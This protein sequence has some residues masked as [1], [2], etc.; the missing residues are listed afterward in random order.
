MPLCSDL[1]KVMIIGSG[2]IVIGQAAEF[3]YAGTQACR[4]LKS[5][6][7]ELVLVN[8]NPA[9]IMTDSSMADK[10]YVEPLDLEILRRIIKKEKPDGLLSTLGGQSGL[11]LSMQL[12]KE[13]FLEKQ[14]VRL[15]GSKYETINRAE[16]RQLFKDTMEEIG[17]PCTKSGTATDVDTAL[18]LARDIGYPVIIRPAF[19]LG[20]S[21][22]G[23]AGNDEELLHAAKA[24]IEASPIGQI[25]VER[26]VAGWKEIEFEVIRDALGNSITVCSMEN[27]DPVGVHTGDSVVVAPALTLAD[28][29][30][31]MLRS[32]AL[33][34][35]DALGVEGGCNV[36]YALDPHSFDYTV[37]EVNPRVSRSSALASK[38]TGYP[39]AKVA[40][41]IAV[42]FTLGEIKN[43]VTGKTSAFFEPA[44]DYVVVKFPKWPFDKFVYADR[45]L[46]TQMK[47]TGEVM[48][49]A[50]TFEEALM[51]AVRGAEL[52]M[53]TLSLPSQ[54]ELSDADLEKAAARAT[55]TRLFAVYEA[56]RRGWPVERLNE[57]TNIDPWFLRAMKNIC[58]MEKRLSQGFD[59]GLY[60]D[61]KLMSFTDAAIERLSGKK[62]ASPA[63]TVFRM[64]DTCAA[65][66]EAETPYF[67]AAHFGEDEAAPY[68]G[69]RRAGKRRILVLGSGPIRIG[70]G[71]EFDY[72]CVKCVWALQKLGCEVALVNNNPE[73]VSTDFDTADRLY[74][75]PLTPEDVMNVIEE[76]RPD[77]VVAAFG[78]GTAIKLT[79]TLAKHGVPILGTS[80]DSIDVAEDRERFDRILEQNGI[81][82]PAGDTVRTK[83]EAVAAANKLGYPV[84]IRPS[85]VLGGQ[86]MTIAACDGDVL[87]YMEI[88][89]ASGNTDPILID[90][91]LN[92]T[93]VEVDAVCDGKDVLI[94]GVMAHVERAGVHSGDSI[95]QYPARGLSGEVMEKIIGHTRS[96]AV[97]LGTK[98]LINIQYVV[99]DNELYVIEANPRASRTVPYI[100]KITGVPVIDLAVRAML[101]EKLENM[102]YGTGLYRDAAVY[103]AKVPVFSFRKL[104]GADSL[105]GPEMKSTGEVLGVA[106][107]PQEALV[108]GL[109]AAGYDMKREG[110][111]LLSV[112]DSDKYEIVD[113]ARGFASLGFRLYATRRTAERLCSHGIAVTSVEK[114]DKSDDITRLL[115]SGAVQYGVLTSTYGGRP[116]REGARCRAKLVERNIPCLTSIDTAR[117]LVKSLSSGY[118]TSNIEILRLNELPEKKTPVRFVKMRATGNDYIYFDCFDQHID[119]PE[120]LSVWISNR[121]TG[122]GSDGIVLIFPDE[123]ADAEMVMYNADG[124][125]GEVAGNAL[126]C[127]GKYLYDSGRIRKENMIIR[128]NRRTN[129]LK[130]YVHDGEVYAVSVEL[131]RPDFSAKNVPV[132]LPFDE[133]VDKAVTVEGV[134]YRLTCLSMGNP[135]CVIFTDDAEGVPLEKV[136]PGLE[137]AEI[138][139]KRANISFAQIVNRRRMNLRVFERGIG[140]TAACGTGAAAAVAAGVKCGL[141]DEEGDVTV[142]MRG[143]AIIVKRV[144]GNI[145]ISG[146]VAVDFEGVVKL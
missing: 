2:P 137:N 119:N 7:L 37:I 76:E 54:A 75:E 138:F 109:L 73:T 139:P 140:E 50:V 67:Y 143:G 55:D 110:G 144:A 92:G 13:G 34:I 111:V 99:C 15:L 61:A 133:V 48:S 30:Y 124:T 78:G 94:P 121:R 134:E 72:A 26:S 115:E 36:Q 120:A 17:E 32:S 40:S 70:Q 6:G 87:E 85:Y 20:G 23:F 108:K 130:L 104:V 38:A 11:T 66:F 27:I 69:K 84:L 97:E 51:K 105:L 35:I 59:D 3:D 126:R 142:R 129:S 83:E 113:V 57:I 64:V 98:G 18:A 42:G 136:G 93:E 88:I 107:T 21:G 53:D 1:K 90:K 71:I 14:H 65:E 60:N 80:A 12:W 123:T 24:G 127:V 10:I 28:R 46:G 39:I 41:L 43:A 100:S 49:I 8:P 29:E 118:N 135:H 22:G 62:P 33:R 112:K 68:A 141:L 4:A 114:L 77:G 128:T 89:L 81:L 101:G 44:L 125:E 82:R 103:A 95:A 45:S 86:N 47:A 116:E 5:V 102:G 63:K 131:G 122:I 31:Q 52:G 106:S 132:D 25:L 146:D 145:S 19:T 74:F 16:D 79:K 96:I 117:A 9:T 58:D 56:L 91:Y